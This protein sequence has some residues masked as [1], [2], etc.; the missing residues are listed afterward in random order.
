M[1]TLSQN[2]GASDA[3]TILLSYEAA[4]QDAAANRT[5]IRFLCTLR[6]NRA[7]ATFTARRG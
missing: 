3:Y 4:S 5:S 6:S 2:F 1:E 7:S